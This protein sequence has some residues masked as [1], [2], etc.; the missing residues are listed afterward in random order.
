MDPVVT[1]IVIAVVATGF[2]KIATALAVFRCGIGLQGVEFALVTLVVAFAIAF[3][4]IPAPLRDVEARIW[5]GD[6]VTLAALADSM[7]RSLPSLE[8]KID[9]G[10]RKMF[11]GRLGMLAADGVDRGGQGGG[12]NG[13]SQSESGSTEGEAVVTDGAKRA[14]EQ[15]LVNWRLPALIVSEVKVALSLGLTLLVPFLLM[16]LLVAHLLTLL[17]VSS[18]SAATVAL[19]LKLMVFLSING[20]ELFIT[21]L[22]G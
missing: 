19:P 10:V 11:E 8:S 21:K 5:R 13:A 22:L 17:G 6:T 12:I 16:D 18:I 14:L 15:S 1:M 9:P 20:W 3:V 2:V 4:S 7:S